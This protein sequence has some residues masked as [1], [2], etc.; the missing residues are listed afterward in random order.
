LNQ[1]VIKNLSWSIT[2][3]EIEAVITYSQQRKS[4]SWWI[5]CWILPDF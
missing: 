1:E 2:R 5:H 4:Q 3:N